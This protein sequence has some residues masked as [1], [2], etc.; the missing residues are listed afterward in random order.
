MKLFRIIVGNIWRGWFFV[1]A[2]IVFLIL[3]PAVVI[4]I[5]R[6][7]WYPLVF[8]LKRVWARLILFNAGI[9]YKTIK[10]ARLEAGRPYVFCPNHTSILDIVISYVAI[11]HYFHFMGKAELKKVP[12][13]RI[14]FRDMNIP[15][16]RGSATASHRAFLRARSDLQK[17]ISIGIFPEATIH[18]CAP[19]IGPVKNGAFR[20][21]IDTGVEIVPITYINCWK[22]IPDGELKKYGGRPGLVKIYIHEP[23]STLALTDADLPALKQKVMSTISSVLE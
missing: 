9:R 12:L 21:A 15:V 2:F 22:I 19:K 17:K 11:P 7:K 16:D 13:F 1:N 8:K 3:Y 20:L 10:S 5:S 6:E 14:F 23:I 18:A 4:L